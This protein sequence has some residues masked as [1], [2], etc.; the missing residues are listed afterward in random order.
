MKIKVLTIVL[1]VCLIG[2]LIWGVNS[3]SSAETWKQE[4]YYTQEQ[5]A[6]YQEQVAQYQYDAILLSF[7]ELENHHEAF[8]DFLWDELTDYERECWER[9]GDNIF[10]GLTEAQQQAV[11]EIFSDER[12]SFPTKAE[13][14]RDLLEIK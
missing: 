13:K 11:T 8:N 6:E 14:L 4:A 2:A 12:T 1:G 9:W 7:I 3:Y 5:L 10:N